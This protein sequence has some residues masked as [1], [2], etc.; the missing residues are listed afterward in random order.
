MKIAVFHEL[1]KGGAKIAVEEICKRLKEKHQVDLFYTD[2]IRDYESERNFSKAYFYRF[3]PKKWTGNDWRTRVYKDSLE[4]IKLYYLHKKIA[5]DIR[6]ISYDLFFINASKFIESPFV[7]R[8]KNKNKIFYL[9]DPHDRS[10]YES[11]GESEKLD[12]FRTFYTVVNRAIKKIIDRRN[13]KG[14]DF[15]LANSK[16]TQTQFGKT[17]GYRS[18]VAYL[19]V[20]VNFFKPLKM[21]KDFDILYIGSHEFV[22]G[23]SLLKASLGLIDKNIKVKNIFFEETWLDKAELKDLYNKS[24]IVLCLSHNEPFGM[25]PLEAM[26]CGVPVIA[27]NEGGY[28]ETIV[29]GKTGYLVERNPE[30]LADKIKSLV[31]DPKKAREM[32]IHARKDMVENWSWKK[33]VAKIEK[34]MEKLKR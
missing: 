9:H 26:A 13:M 29:N 4:L 21:K 22:D 32:G 18:K 19:G 15:F 33:K 8:F 24:G 5:R 27:V 6:R 1:P 3:I 2:E 16:Y 31:S 11:M 25:V 20:D 10:L 28:R 23:Y 30:K 17:Y 34:I 7:M 12:S 14:V